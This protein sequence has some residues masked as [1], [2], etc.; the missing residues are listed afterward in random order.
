MVRNIKNSLT[1]KMILNINSSILPHISELLNILL[2]FSANKHYNSQA[3][4]VGEVFAC[5][6]T[7]QFQYRAIKIN[8]DLMLRLLE[9]HI[10]S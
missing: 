5:A 3:E 8:Q 7:T 10:Y 1:V 4:I 6:N 2:T 9:M